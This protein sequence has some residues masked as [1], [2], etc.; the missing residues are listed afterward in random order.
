MC[1]LMVSKYLNSIKLRSIK[2]MNM[3]THSFDCE[4]YLFL[5]FV[6]STNFYR[7]VSSSPFLIALR[8]L[9]AMPSPGPVTTV[10]LL[11]QE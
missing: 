11:A 2:N 10:R 4:L 6:Q 5:N 3:Y 8:A 7:I 9:N 1:D